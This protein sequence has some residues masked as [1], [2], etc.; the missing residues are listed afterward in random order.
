MNIKIWKL[1]MRPVGWMASVC[2]AGLALA[3]AGAEMKEPLPLPHAHSHNDYE[4]SRPLLDALDQ[5]FCSIE[6]DVWLVNGELLVAHD[7]KDAKPGRTLQALYLDP[8]QARVERNG[9]RVFRN[10]PTVTLL[11]DV[12]S[13][14]TNSYVLLRDVLKRYEKMLTRFA[15]GRTETNAVTVIISGNRARGLMAAEP[16]R[17]AAYD[18]RLVDLDA[19]DSAHFIPLISDNWTLHFKWRGRTSDGPLPD[20]ERAK[21]RSIVA[22]AHEQ[23]RRLRFWATPDTREMWAELDSAGVDLIN[24]DDLPGLG[25][26]LRARRS[27]K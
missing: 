11:V 24:A 18:G 2:L 26:F 25:N 12:K 20:S 22:R 4:H 19:T 21:L 3:A 13:D 15:P 16:A 8:L 14:A 9:G 5:G 17:L 23:G 7:L 6:A 1:L 10:G 27:A